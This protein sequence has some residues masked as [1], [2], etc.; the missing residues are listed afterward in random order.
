MSLIIRSNAFSISSHQV[1]RLGYGTM[2]LTGPGAFGP[3]KDRDAAFTVL[4]GAVSLG[5]NHIDTNDFY[6]P[7]VT[8]RL[9]REALYPCRDDLFIVTKVGVRRG[10]EGAWLPAFSV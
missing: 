1:H 3:P 10:A 4:R 7:H 5:I 8:S 6:S 9:I 2:Q